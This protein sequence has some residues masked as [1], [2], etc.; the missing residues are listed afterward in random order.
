MR[1][2]AALRAESRARDAFLAK[3]T[4]TLVA[5]AAALERALRAQR[6]VPARVCAA[7]T[8][9]QELLRELRI[10]ATPAAP[11][12]LRQVEVEL[13]G[14]LA[15]FFAER[16]KLW[17]QQG[18]SLTL[19][20]S[21]AV[22][23]R[24]DVAHLATMLDELLS[25]ALKYRRGRPAIVQLALARRHVTIC[26]T[27]QGGWVGAKPKYRRFQRGEARRMPGFGVGLWLTRRLAEAHGGSLR[28]RAEASQTRACISL[29]LHARSA[30][31]VELCATLTPT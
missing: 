27:N 7:N 8:S 14:T 31:P 9:L 4:D 1:Q 18:L 5:S 20:R 21:G 12:A 28:I 11:I 2:L 13:C 19:R 25:N 26:V 30:G 10:I 22:Y 16:K 15:A 29:P 3:A 23:C 17:H 24:V 6:F